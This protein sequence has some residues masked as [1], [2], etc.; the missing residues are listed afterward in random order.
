MNHTKTALQNL[1]TPEMVGSTGKYLILEAS[2][3]EENLHFRR[4]RDFI[5]QNAERASNCLA[6]YQKE[7]KENPRE[8]GLSFD[9]QKALPYPKLSVSLD[10]YKL[11]FHN[12][13]D[14]NVKMYV[15]EETTASRGAQKVAACI[16]MHMEATNSQQHVIAYSDA[17]SGH[18]GNIKAALTWTKIAEPANNNNEY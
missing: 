17:C 1:E 14:D 16:L 13:H 6:E 8:H 9:L 5:L 10:Y 2:N 12:F 11:G 15:R 4:N 3:E 7:A 18:M